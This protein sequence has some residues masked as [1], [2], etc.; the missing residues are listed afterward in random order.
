[1]TV[2]SALGWCWM[3]FLLE[4]DLLRIQI[5]QAD[6]LCGKKEVEHF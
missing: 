3:I 5:K 6:G 1:M 4:Q 2:S